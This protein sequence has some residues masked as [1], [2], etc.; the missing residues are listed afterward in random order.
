MQD[1]AGVA[2][3]LPASQ[4]GVLL[5]QLAGQHSVLV[6][7]LLLGVERF[8]FLADLIEAQVAHNDRVHH[9]IRVVGVLILFQHGHAD[10]GQD[11]DLAAGG[12]Q[13]TGED[14]QKRGLARAVGANDAVAVALDEL[15]VHVGEQRLAAV[16][17]PQISDSNHRCVKLL[18]LPIY[19]DN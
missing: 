8:L 11:R 12:L 9:S 15:Q 2:L 3:G 17:Q 5:L 14:F 6:G 19:K 18:F 1:T 13:L 16:L 10:F 7:H 4:L